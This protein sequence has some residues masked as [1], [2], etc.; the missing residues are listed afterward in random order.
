MQPEIAQQLL[1]L[2]HQFYQTFAEHFSETRQ[3]I[4]PGVVKSIDSIPKTAHVLD[5]G[6]G[7]GQ[8]AAHLNGQG[9]TGL[10]VGLDTSANL[11]EI[12]KQQNLPN[13]KFFQ[14]D[15]TGNMWQEK[16]PQTL[17]D[18]VV[19]FAVLHH[20]PSTRLRVEFLNKVRQHLSP[21]GLF[22]H[23]N[24]QFLQSPKLRRR[25]QPW[26]KVGLTADLVEEH[27]YL[28]DWRRGGA[29]FRYVHYYTSDELS[30]LADQTGFKVRG[31]FLSDGEGGRLGLYQVWEIK[32]N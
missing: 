19:C 5:L 21:N 23:S 28:L 10:Y 6:C 32:K 27:D 24:W 12:A 1:E 4:Q 14:A 26:E 17:F 8:L 18:T 11:I 29:G 15:L 25:I 20:I 31:E 22:I 9:Y 7:N 16:L 2:N 30:S 13:A 3:R